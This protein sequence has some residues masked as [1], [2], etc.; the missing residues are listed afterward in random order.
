MVWCERLADVPR[1]LTFDEALRWMGGTIEQYN[2][3]A[4]RHKALVEWAK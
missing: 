4:E 1:G 3:C 2:R